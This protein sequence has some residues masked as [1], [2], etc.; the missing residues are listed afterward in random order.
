MTK[1]EYKNALREIQKFPLIETL[2][3]IIKPYEKRIAELEKENA[4]LKLKLEALDSETPWKDIKDKSEAVG[5]LIKT[6]EVLH[7]F[8]ELKTKPCA[9]GNSINMLHFENACKKAEQFLSEVGI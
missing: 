1:E 8:L 4:E 9:S 2:Q 3:E 7:L 5:Q 6:K